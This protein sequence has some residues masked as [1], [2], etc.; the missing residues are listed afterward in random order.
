M[1]YPS[2]AELVSARELVLVREGKWAL[3]KELRW[4]PWLVLLR[5]L[6]KEQRWAGKWVNRL[7]TE[8][9][10]HLETKK[11]IYWREM[12]K[13]PSLERRKERQWAKLKTELE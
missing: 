13:E 9:A 8:R 1:E 5:A 7:E 12:R 6:G 10:E 2:I 3:G 11:A 4:A